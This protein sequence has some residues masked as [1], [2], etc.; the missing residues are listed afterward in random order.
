M[1]DLPEGFNGE[2]KCSR[3]PERDAVQPIALRRCAEC[4]EDAR[5]LYADQHGREYTQRYQDERSPDGRSIYA[6]MSGKMKR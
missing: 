4:L 5:A 1:S 2:Y 6:E 3:H